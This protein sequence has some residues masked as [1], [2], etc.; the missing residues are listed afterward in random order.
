MS[1]L[2]FII[3]PEN[4]NGDP[5]AKPTTNCIA[6]YNQGGSGGCGCRL[7][8]NVGF[9]KEI[10]NTHVEVDESNQHVPS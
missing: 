4:V 1:K 6:C 3:L 7:K 8:K 2:S 5:E 9:F 10:T